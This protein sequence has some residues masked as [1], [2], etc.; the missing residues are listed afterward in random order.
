[1]AALHPRAEENDDFIQSIL[2]DSSPLMAS[3]HRPSVQRSRS[4]GGKNG[5]RS[6]KHSGN[7]SAV[8]MTEQDV[9]SYGADA[10]DVSKANLPAS[11]AAARQ[12]SGRVMAAPPPTASEGESFQQAY[13]REKAEEQMTNSPNHGQYTPFDRSLDEAELSLSQEQDNRTHA[14]FRYALLFIN[15]TFV[16]AAILM[17]MAGVVARFNSALQLCSSCGRLTLASII[18]GGTQ[19]LLALFAFNWIRERNILFLLGYV[20]AVLVI[21]LCLVGIFIAGA[22]VS[23]NLTAESNQGD[24]L[25]QWE[26]EVNVTDSNTGESV[27]CPL[28]ARYNCSGFQYGCCNPEYCFNGTFPDWAPRVCPECPS[29]VPGT[30]LCTQAITRSAQQNLGGFVVIT[31]FSILLAV[32]GIALAAFSRKMTK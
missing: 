25:E 28:Q 3:P 21:T 20:G 1:M 19:W 18:L 32:T 26:Q 12:Q 9:V 24:L 22:T 17:V 16:V 27:L 8:N 23:F 11:E 31:F 2:G 10:T 15:F 30:Q 29:Q 7:T 13:L 14:L 5:R 6:G 4:T